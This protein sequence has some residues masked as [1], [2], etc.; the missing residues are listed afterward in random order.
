MVDYIKYAKTF[1]GPKATSLLFSFICGIASTYAI[2]SY[3]YHQGAESTNTIIAAKDQDIAQLNRQ[4]DSCHRDKNDN[5]KVEIQAIRNASE[6]CRIENIQL[7]EYNA[8]LA[9]SYSALQDNQHTTKL[10]LDQSNSA[11]STRADLENREA[12]IK[13]RIANAERE[14]Y[15]Q[16]ERYGEA[17]ELCDQY[18][19]GENFMGG[20]SPEQCVR[21][22]KLRESV[23]TLE[24][25]FESERREL[26]AIQQ[27]I[28]GA[29]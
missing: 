21:A 23:L 2:M 15:M 26:V 13:G 29:R 14:I 27:S 5:I 6:Q 3:V 18:H 19:R 4:I 7:R 9:K 10:K 28:F 25:S 22:A 24:K 1:F 8:E 16:R 12:L 11:N 17:K 20:A